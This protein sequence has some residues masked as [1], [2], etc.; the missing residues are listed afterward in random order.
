M[1]LTVTY[2]SNTSQRIKRYYWAVWAL[3]P[4]SAIYSVIVLNLVQIIALNQTRN[5]LKKDGK[6]A[7][8]IE[9]GKAQLTLSLVVEVIA[10]RN[11]PSSFK[12]GF[13]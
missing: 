6:V 9:E 8:I 5:P 13:H 3:S 2:H 10:D 4:I 11:N 12:K 1:P 7:A